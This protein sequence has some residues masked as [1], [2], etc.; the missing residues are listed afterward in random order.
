VGGLQVV[1]Y[2]FVYVAG[3]ERL[4]WQLETSVERLLLQVWPT[5][6]VG[7]LYLTRDSAGTH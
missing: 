1:G 3:S 7:W 2:L 5:A 6:V 4:E